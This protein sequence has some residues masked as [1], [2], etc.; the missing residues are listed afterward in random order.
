LKTPVD[1]AR[2]T[3]G[4]TTRRKHPV[5]GYTRAHKGVDMA[6]PTGT[7]IYA[8]GDGVVAEIKLNDRSYGKY[9]LIRHNSEYSTKYAHMS[10]V[11][12]IKKGQRVKQRQVIGY[13]GM[14]GLATGPHLHYEVIRYGKHVNPSKINAVEIKK[15][16]NSKIPE[17]KKFVNYID[18][19][20]KN[21]T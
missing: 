1:G 10:R 2:I 3:S 17:F 7:P 14:T 13:V 9:V 11:A 19:T 15:L 6:V 5:L 16:D 8:A 21:L 4:F 20:L 18:N 12:N